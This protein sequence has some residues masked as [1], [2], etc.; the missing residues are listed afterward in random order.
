MDWANK[1]VVFVDDEERILS[2]LRRELLDE[3][4]EVR[5]HC[6]P[7][8]ALQDI[9]DDP[10]DVVVADYVMPNMVGADL[11]RHVREFDDN[12]A[13]VLLTGSPDL[14]G[15]MRAVNEGHIYSLL[16][17]PWHQAEL[18]QAVR[19]AIEF[20]H[21]S[22]ARDGLLQTVVRQRNELLALAQSESPSL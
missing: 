18:R 8:T 5:L 6:D 19:K 11:L 21:L 22:R 15:F 2:A 14:S 13:R 12:I 7:E 4:Y 17:K 20:S 9:T 1:T 10:P 16:L 3:P